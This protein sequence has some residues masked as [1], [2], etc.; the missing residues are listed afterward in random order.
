MIRVGSY[1]WYYNRKDPLP[2]TTLF[3]DC[4]V[5]LIQRFPINLTKYF[6][7]C[8]VVENWQRHGMLVKGRGKLEVFEL[9]QN[10]DVSPNLSQGKYIPVLRMGN[11]NIVSSLPSY[12]IPGHYDQLEQVMEI[13]NSYQ[14]PTV[15]AGDMHWEDQHI[16]SLYIK[17]QLINHMHSPTFTGQHGERLSLDKI[18]TNSGVEISDIV[19]HENLAKNNIE[20]YPMEFTIN[21]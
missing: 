13:A 19:V 7:D 11:L 18:L 20:H 3:K 4:D 5:I 10:E 12:G 1:V 21:V 17:H 15:V 2:I 8:H 16:N 6:G 9:L 14:E